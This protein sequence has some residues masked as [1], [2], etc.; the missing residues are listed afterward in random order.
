MAALKSVCPR[1]CYD[2]CHLAVSLDGGELRVAPDPGFAF[3]AGFLCPRGAVEARRVFSA[4]R[5]LFPYRRA[6]GKPGRSF[7]RVEW[8]SALDEVASRLKEVLEEHGPGA[9]LHLEYA[10]N[11]GLLTWYYPQRLWNW[12]GAART[13][14]SICSKSGHEAL[15][16]HYGLSYGRTP[17]E[18]EGSR[19]FVFWGFN[20]SVSSPHLWAAALRGRR[21]GSVIAAVDPRRSET[22]LKSDFAVHPRPGTDV[23]LAYGVINYLISEGLYDED[24][25]ERYTVGF[26]ELRRE[27]SRWS[28]SRVSGVTGVGEKDVARLAELYAELKPSTT[29]I[30]FGVQKGVNG[31]EAVRA[32]SLIPALVGQHRGFYYSNSRRWLVDLAAVTGERHAP[33]GRV[34]SQ[35]ALAELVERGE[36][37]FIYVYNMNPLLTLPGQ[38]KLRRGLSRSDVFVVLHD[39]H[40]NETADYADVVLPAATYLEKDDVVIP[41]AHG[42]VAMSRKVIEPLGESR[43]EVWVT[44]ELARRLGAPEWVCRDPLDVLREAL[45]GALE[46]SFEDLLAGKTLRLKARRLDEY[47]TPSGRIE[48]Y[49]RRA[50]ELGFSPLPVQGEYDG[51]GFVLLNSATPLYTHTQFRDVYGP[52]PAVVHVNPVDAERLGVRDGDLVELYN[53]HGSVVVKAQVTELVPPGVLW[54]PRQLVG[55]D[56]SPQNSL[57]PTETQRIGGGPVFNSTRVFARPARVI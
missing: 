43:S 53:E 3:T 38:G 21:R 51:E 8:G 41:Y 12:L 47:Q 10:G 24:F 15:S 28:L 18:A 56:G 40:W 57:V 50:L 31:A 35:V 20:A 14:Y 27:A 4:G 7:E 48:L 32:V 39:T 19:L 46:G 9:V 37:K 44:C 16:L 1:D 49:S 23:A 2:T 5:V 25:V 52:I 11:M 26:E 30:G 17:E 33:P 55:L 29:F 45:G 54:S 42:Y 36:F 34:V 22:A 6:G 13:D